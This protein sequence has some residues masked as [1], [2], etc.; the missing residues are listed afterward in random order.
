LIENGLFEEAREY[1]LKD[2]DESYLKTKALKNLLK[3][4]FKYNSVLPP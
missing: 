2:V 4:D 3:F 1:L